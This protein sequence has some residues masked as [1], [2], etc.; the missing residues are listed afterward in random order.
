MSAREKRTFSFYQDNQAKPTTVVKKKNLA[1]W[2]LVLKSPQVFQ[3][4]TISSAERVI[5]K[6]SVNQYH[7]IEEWLKAITNLY[8]SFEA[9][10]ICFIP[11]VVISKGFKMSQFNK[12]NG[13]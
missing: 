12:L 11:D 6:A 3:G 4:W 8:G 13:S 10:K 2:D 9:T 1:T 5:E 7:L